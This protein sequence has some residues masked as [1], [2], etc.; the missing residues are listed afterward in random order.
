[1]RGGE[2]VADLSGRFGGAGTGAI[3]GE[4]CAG[5]CCSL[6]A[7]HPCVH[8]LPGAHLVHAREA[9]DEAQGAGATGSGDG[10]LLSLGRAHHLLRLGALLL[11]LRL[12][13]AH[14]GVE[15]VLGRH[16][17]GATARCE[18]NWGAQC[19]RAQAQAK[20]GH[21]DGKRLRGVSVY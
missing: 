7:A 9:G 18:R 21:G 15:P 4:P 1:M 6:P 10:T 2:G 12:L 20:G 16:C 11:R 19:G 8:T 3:S 14:R 13:G 17:Q 5:C